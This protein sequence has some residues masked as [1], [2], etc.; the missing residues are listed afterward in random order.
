VEP[1]PANAA[2]LRRNLDANTVPATVVEAAVGPSPG[3]ARFVETRDSNLGRIGD[4]DLKINVVSM[5]EVLGQ[6]GGDVDLLK[7]DIEGGEQALLG[8]DLDWLDQ[9]RAMIIEFHPTLVDYQ[10]LIG[11]VVSRASP[12]IPLTRCGRAAWTSSCGTGAPG[13]RRAVPSRWVRSEVDAL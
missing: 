10:G 7:V 3:R 5:D 13:N 8:G 9:V 1:V 4:G 2:L 6:V 12:T 11:T